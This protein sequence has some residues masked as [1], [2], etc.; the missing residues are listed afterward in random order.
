[1]QEFV[2]AFGEDM[3]YIPLCW[4]CGFAAYDR[5]LDTVTPHGYAPYFGLADW[6]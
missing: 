6:H 3:P 4:R 2:T 1:L 5:R